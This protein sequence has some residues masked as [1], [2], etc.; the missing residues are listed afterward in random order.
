ML[1][2]VLSDLID[3]NAAVLFEQMHECLAVEDSV[4]HDVMN[5]KHIRR[6]LAGKIANKLGKGM[7]FLQK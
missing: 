6:M 4:T 1:P 3:V 7:S 2:E 5:E